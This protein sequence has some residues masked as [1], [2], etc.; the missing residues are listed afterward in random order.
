MNNFK[1][2]RHT[3]A[4]G[5]WSTHIYQTKSTAR[6]RFA[7]TRTTCDFWFGWWSTYT[8]L[9]ETSALMWY[10]WAAIRYWF[11]TK[12]ATYKYLTGKKNKAYNLPYI[13]KNTKA[14]NFHYNI[15]ITWNPNIILTKVSVL[16][17]LI[18]KWKISTG[19]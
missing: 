11:S 14:N 12:V 3:W 8:I 6:K 9:T 15:N 10:S 2:G 16:L 4:A 18:H 7:A 13:I 1:L 5:N 19:L 17:E